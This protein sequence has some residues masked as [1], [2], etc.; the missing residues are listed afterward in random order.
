MKRR[1]FIKLG[2][3][4]LGMAGIAAYANWPDQG[5]INPC[6]ALPPPPD[7]LDHELV[8]SAWRGID[9]TRVWD[10]HAHI[11]GVG[12]SP[13]TW[14]N[15]Q[16]D[17]WAHPLQFAQK[18][19]FLNAGCADA[20]PGRTDSSYVDR[21]V[22]LH[23]SGM[24]QAK[25]MLLAFDY[26]YDEK[27]G[28]IAARSAFY[29]ANEYAAGIAYKHPD[30]FEWICSVHPYR[31]DALDAL[32]WAKQHG[33]R[34]VKWLP[35]AMGINPASPLCASYYQVLRELGLPLLT[36]AGAERAVHGMGAEQFGSPLLLRS[37]LDAGVRVIVAHCA[38]MG[39]SPDTDAGKNA[40]ERS[41]FSLFMRMLKEARYNDLLYGDI[42]A[43]TQANRAHVA[44]AALL[45]R[46]DLHSRLLNGSDYPLPGVMP[47]FSLI[48]L[49]KLKLLDE[50][51][52]EILS[53][54]RRFNPLLF[55][56]V[57]KRTLR[58]NGQG[59]L[60]ELFETKGFFMDTA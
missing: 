23:S 8:Q 5:M 40:P 60:P 31:S 16:M 38:S 41:N 26:A 25:S 15:P 33:A 3:A 9:A 46:Q 12:N 19:F 30:H 32:R 53:A 37:A 56:F 21:L 34:A 1:T 22:A 39:E 28:R 52:I 17:S 54:L 10:C 59:F 14:I 29:A 45:L 24:R 6:L 43:I 7:I 57:L 47:L 35:A 13:G 51:H 42:S 18:R 11:I 55:D 20:T 49:V 48:Q 27:G 36:H 4:G 44:L 2:A 50:K 58:L